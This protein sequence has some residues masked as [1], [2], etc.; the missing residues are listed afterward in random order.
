MCDIKRQ[1]KNIQ[2]GKLLRQPQ[3]LHQEEKNKMKILSYAYLK[4]S[5]L[6]NQISTSMI[7]KNKE[8]GASAFMPVIFLKKERN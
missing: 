7:Y 4:A 1:K 6:S 3:K 2:K 8:A 5:T